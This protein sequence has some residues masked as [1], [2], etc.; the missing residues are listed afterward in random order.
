MAETD[1]AIENTKKILA[2]ID[3]FEDKM[4]EV[5]N[6]C[7]KI[8][9]LRQRCDQAGG[10]MDQIAMARSGTRPPTSNRR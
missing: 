6:V 10:R 2:K 4:E 8:R 3:E 1:R 7:R 5:R 9:A